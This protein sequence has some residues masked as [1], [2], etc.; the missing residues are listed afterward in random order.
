MLNRESAQRMGGG[1]RLLTIL[2]V[3]AFLGLLT[4]RGVATFWTDY[5]WFSSV[6]LTSVWWTL[7]GS[8]LLLALAAAL[9]AFV[10]LWVNL[11][12]ADRLSP[13]LG[14]FGIHADEELV[15]RF[16]EW[17][18]PRIRRVR[19]GLSALLALVIGLGA[20]AWW[21]EVLLFFNAQSF[22]GVDPLFG[23]DLG[24]YVFR[25][26]LY[27]D[28]FGWFFQLLVITSLLVAGL[29][30]L[31]GGIRLQ[32]DIQRVT[33]AV[34]V[35][36]SVLLAALAVLKAIG[37]RLDTY[38]LLYSRRGAVFGATYTDVH[39]YLPALNLLTLISL[40]AAVLLLV[41]IRFR[42]WT[43][44]A[45][46]GGLWLG[47]AVVV[48][49][50]IPAAVQRFLVE[51]AELE[52][53]RPFIDRNIQLTRQAYDLA[54][55]QV[56]PFAASGEL[57]SEDLAANQA[58][59]DNVR[60]WDPTVLQ[61]TYEQLQ[62]IRTYYRFLDVDVDR[63]AL[64]DLTQVMFSIREL[65]EDD[66]PSNSWV[67]RRLVYT[68]GY[69]AV[70]SPANNVTVEGQ[71]AFFVKDL[72]PQ[73]ER[74]PLQIDQAGV[75][76]GE[77]FSRGD[78]V[79]VGTNAQEVDFPQS[80]GEGDGEVEYTTYAGSAGV[81]VGNL[82]K[83]A[84]FALRFGDVNTLISDQ[85]TGESK[86][87]MA[88]NIRER[89][90]RVAPFLHSDADPYPVVLGGRLMWVIDLYTTSDRY[91]Y[92][93]P[94]DVRRLSVRTGLP[95]RFNYLRNSV[96]A[97]VDAYNGNATLYVVDPEDPVVQAYRQIFPQLFTDGAAMP[98]ELREHLRYPEDLFRVQ[99]DMYR[100]YHMTDPQVFY[101]N[102]D[103]WQIPADP[104]DTANDELIGASATADLMVPYYLLMRL[105]EDE[106]LSFLIMQP[107]TP[108]QKRNMI[109]FLVAKSGPEDYGEMITFQLP[110]QEFVDGPDQVG[111][112]INQDPAIAREFTLLGQEGSQLI[113]GNMLVVPIE[114]SL[115]YVQPVYLQGAQ[116][117]LPEFKFAVVVFEDRI[118][119]RETLDEALAEL[120]G[121]ERVVEGDGP[122]Q[123]QA[124]L[125]GEALE[126]LR[127]AGEA[128]AEADQALQQQPP[129]LRLYAEKVA[130]ARELVEQAL[131]MS[132]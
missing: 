32:P 107:F 114:E 47:T 56:R 64:N 68:H 92:S 105:P 46:A 76:F 113:Q 8:R 6:N 9:V 37:Y 44:P 4:L 21:E 126:L 125:E 118:T 90:E 52:R 18:E 11:V 41:N 28:L 57:T 39:A 112:R 2:L 17:V 96:K 62:E 88:R 81:P 25:L 55:V 127:Q 66:L 33:P 67:N 3:L 69:G 109:S 38:D 116:V 101:S 131:A 89:V 50:I 83:R 60:L 117:Q 58:T 100:T 115:L 40:F 45:V 53:E 72:P 65:N 63:Y 130:E 30:Y 102:E 19:L 94:A 79:I 74:P 87:L 42:G 31:N 99:S 1:R 132:E 71:P 13:R 15:E 12:V 111:A 14:I 82:V 106:D 5:L 93:E 59:I 29:H 77:T 78:F 27:R 73:T 119:M 97:T 95:L 16:Q 48:G 85:L 104:S 98:Q 110:R 86:V 124:P 36:L 49:G 26:P 128:F 10:F 108:R 51:P 61:T 121:G 24:F 43:L 22:G 70:V 20:A 34:K 120:F 91:P 80:I 122:Q 103:A 84:A 75:Y 23:N 123:A 7:V 35:H 129:D 54:S